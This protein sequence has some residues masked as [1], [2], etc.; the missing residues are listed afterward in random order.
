[1]AKAKAEDQISEDGGPPE[2]DGLVTV[3]AVERV[4]RRAENRTYEPGE[5]VVLEAETAAL[6]VG[7]GV[8]RPT[9]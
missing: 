8:V 7:L 6:L 3:V 2:A 9:E 1:M 5:T 4:H